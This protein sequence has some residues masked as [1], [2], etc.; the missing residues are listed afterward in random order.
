MKFSK[1]PLNKDSQK[2][3]V[4]ETALEQLG[5][6]NMNRPAPQTIPYHEFVS[7]KASIETSNIKPYSLLEDIIMYNNRADQMIVD[8]EIGT[9]PQKFNVLLDTGS[10]VLW[11]ANKDFQCVKMQRC[12]GIY[13]HFDANRSSTVI[14]NTLEPVELSYGTGYVQGYGYNDKVTFPGD[15][16]GTMSFNFVSAERMNF[17]FSDGILGV[18]LQN[19]SPN[20]GEE[21]SFLDQLKENNVISEV[22][23]SQ[24]YTGSKQGLLTIGEHTPEVQAHIAAN[25]GSDEDIGF[26]NITPTLQGIY[27]NPYW[28]CE[29]N[30]IL[31]G[32]N[33]STNTVFEDTVIFDTGSNFNYVTA[34]FANAISKLFKKFTDKKQCGWYLIKEQ[35]TLQFECDDTRELLEL[36]S[37]DFVFVKMVILVTYYQSLLKNLK[38]QT[39]TQLPG[40]PLQQG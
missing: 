33:W 19:I 26:C 14:R 11:V 2:Q 3:S 25:G 30:R 7:L 24:V 36:E 31:L 17:D 38:R 12:Q 39:E 1:V 29:A 15:E 37:L 10:N 35:D 8:I 16:F 4:V 28:S 22:L 6:A 20:F 18:G 21:Y 34:K 9:P 13:H 5:L 40:F 32:H 27:K 23:L